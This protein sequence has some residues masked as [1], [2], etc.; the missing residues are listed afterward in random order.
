MLIY[1]NFS[2][3]TPNPGEKQINFGKYRCSVKEEAILL[4]LWSALDR[5]FQ[6]VK[7]PDSCR[8]LSFVTRYPDFTCKTPFGK[9]YVL[10]ER[11]NDIAPFVGH[12][13]KMSWVSLV[14][15]DLSLTPYIK[16][17][18]CENSRSVAK[19]ASILLF[20]WNNLVHNIFKVANIVSIVL[21][22]LICHCL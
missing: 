18:Y 7:C 2:L 12:P 5:H 22:I 13:V 6:H 4:L 16:H 19:E 11:S 8:S 17:A 21:L 9:F 3:L 15:F 1:F 14:D 10:C 20:S